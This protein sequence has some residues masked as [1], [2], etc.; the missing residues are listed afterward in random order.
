MTNK[1]TANTIL[2][3][4]GGNKFIAMTGAYNF[5]YGDKWLSFRYLGR[6]GANYCNII[7]DSDDT[8]RMAFQRIRGLDSKIIKESGG[9]YC[10]QLADIFSE[11]TGL[12][13]SIG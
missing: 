8:Y 9:L 3:Q 12:C 6:S 11:Q 1:Q 10:N 13:L 2:A 7:L 5:V 4:L